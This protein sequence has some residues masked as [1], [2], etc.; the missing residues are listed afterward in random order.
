M[1]KVQVI[2]CSKKKPR[3]KD[4]TDENYIKASENS[5]AKQQ[6]KK[7]KESS[8]LADIPLELFEDLLKYK[9][10]SF[11]N[12]LIIES[13]HSEFIRKNNTCLNSLLCVTGNSKYIHIIILSYTLQNYIRDKEEE[14]KKGQCSH[15]NQGL[16]K[17]Q[18]A[19][20]KSKKPAEESTSG[21]SS[22][23][24]KETK[25]NNEKS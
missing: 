23:K 11:T 21:K 8:T 19:K 24:S 20:R 25:L 22:K 17:E 12:G 5:S 3:K 18:I 6:G 9:F 4:K 7:D 13:L 15:K 1:R 10:K 2:S 14:S 16:E